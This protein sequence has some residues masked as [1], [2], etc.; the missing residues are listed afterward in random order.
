MGS[1]LGHPQSHHSLMFT[2]WAFRYWLG[3]YLSVSD[4]QKFR[5]ENQGSVSYMQNFAEILY[6]LALMNHSESKEEKMIAAQVVDNN[7]K[8]SG[9]ESGTIELFAK[10]L[11]I[12]SCLLSG[13]YAKGL[14]KVEYILNK[15]REIGVSG[16][17]GISEALRSKAEFLL[18]K[19]EAERDLSLGE[20]V[21]SVIN[22][23]YNMA[24]SEGLKSVELRCLLTSAKLW[25]K[26]QNPV[27]LQKLKKP[28]VELCDMY[29]KT[30]M[31]HKP[32]TLGQ[33]EKLLEELNINDKE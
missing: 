7:V 2:Q 21:S 6:C 14:E 23:A 31:K 33:V 15:K 3:D 28:I 1:T 19:M 29:A 8:E 18:L 26:L 27:A 24:H 32:A 5:Q 22:E 16:A 13:D 10:H 11:L 4:A 17:Y 20:Q 9:M 25:K 12:Q 30:A